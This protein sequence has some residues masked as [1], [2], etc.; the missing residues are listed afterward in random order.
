MDVKPITSE[1][2]IK[3]SLQFLRRHYRERPRKGDFR[4]E[5]HLRGMGG[6]VVDGQLSYE[7]EDSNRNVVITFEATDYFSRDELRFQPLLPL[8]WWDAIA[9]G[10]LI[11][12]VLMVFAHLEHWLKPI[13]HYFWLGFS[14]L[15]GSVLVF[16]LLI[17]FLFRHWR[18]YRYIYA[19]QQ[20]NQYYVDDQWMAFAWDVFNGPADPYF[21]E[22]QKQC[23]V[24]GY[25]LIE[26]GSDERVHLHVVPSVD[27]PEFLLRRHVVQFFRQNDFTRFVQNRLNAASWSVQF[28]WMDDI[29]YYPAFKKWLKSLDIFPKISINL[30]VNNWYQQL[31]DWFN[32]VQ[33]MERLSNKNDVNRFK[34]PVHNQI[35]VILASILVIGT[36]TWMQYRTRPINVVD[37]LT[38]EQ[39]M[40]RKRDELRYNDQHGEEIR[41]DYQTSYDSTVQF[42]PKT[43]PYI[44]GEGLPEIEKPKNFQEEI[45][46]YTSEGFI[47]YPCQRLYGHGSVRYLVSLGTYQKIEPLKAAILRCRKQGINVNGMWSSCFFGEGKSYLVFLEDLYTARHEAESAAL[48]LQKEL[49]RLQIGATVKIFEVL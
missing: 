36:F 25:G 20:F 2:I 14:I 39:E 40:L 46:V 47:H 1:T 34:R 13:F 31:G 32:R 9:W 18:R 41:G 3:V 5:T 45:V 26:V 29:P 21:I 10:F 27:D 44:S 11:T 6:L 35:G 49:R 38:Y 16:T 33:V 43:Q 42:N 30:P 24:N 28:R 19:I 4:E 17:F 8:R 37:E 48:D 12:A 15:A 23:V 7:E 22:L